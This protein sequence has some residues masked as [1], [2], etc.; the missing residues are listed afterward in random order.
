LVQQQAIDKGSYVVILGD[1]NDFDSTISDPAKSVPISQVLNILK[2]PS[3]S[4]SIL[5]EPAAVT[6]YNAN[7]FV[8]SQ[9]NRYS[10]WYDKD[11]NCNTVGPDEFSLIDHVLISPELK[12]LLTSTDMGHQYFAPLCYSKYSDHWP[13]TITISTKTMESEANFESEETNQP[14]KPDTRSPGLVVGITVGGV[15]IILGAIAIYWVVKKF[16]G[17]PSER[18]RMPLMN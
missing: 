9:A 17:V 3:S 18:E 11:G 13:I 5:E 4:Q 12:T 8:T 14:L 10:C 16:I 1:F 7:A 2:S 6:L 15:F